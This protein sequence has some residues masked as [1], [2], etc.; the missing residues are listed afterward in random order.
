M[1][2]YLKLKTLSVD[3]HPSHCQLSPQYLFWSATKF[4]QAR[5]QS[6]APAKLILSEWLLSLN[7]LKC[8]SPS[9]IL[10][11]L[12]QVEVGFSE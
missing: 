4:N 7:A 3:P 9:C 5:I 10:G 1:Y 2:T 11:M 12:R 6:I 8:Y